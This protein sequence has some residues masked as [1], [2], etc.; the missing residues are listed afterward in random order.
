MKKKRMY[1][2]L[3]HAIEAYNSEL[4]SQGYENEESMHKVLLNEFNMTEK[5][6]MKIMRKRLHKDLKR[7][8]VMLLS[9]Q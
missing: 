3:W 7:S 2:I 5:E 4:D 8:A 6:Y 9:G 1:D